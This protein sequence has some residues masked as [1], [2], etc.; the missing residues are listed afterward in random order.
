MEISIKINGETV[1]RAVPPQTLLVHFIRDT[2]GLTG[3]HWGVTHPTAVPASCGS[4]A[5]P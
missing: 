5:W 2:P 4:T 3:T 1:T